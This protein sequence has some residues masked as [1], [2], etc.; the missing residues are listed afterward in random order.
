MT[1][2]S[3]DQQTP[4]TF[5]KALIK[6]HEGY[7]DRLYRCTAGK[8]T[9]GFGWNVED[10]PICTEAATAQLDHQLDK[11]I[12]AL[13]GIFPEFFSM[14]P[15]RQSALT[16]MMFNLGPTRFQGFRRMIAA[17]KLGHWHTAAAEAMDS[18]WC[19][20]VGSRGERIVQILRTGN[21]TDEDLKLCQV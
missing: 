10:T 16:D 18:K 9:I 21:P 15:W 8:L 13:H 19:T 3:K 6:L 4:R 12:I 17:I 1:T 14:G 2:T 20:Q 7:R 11:A 5:S